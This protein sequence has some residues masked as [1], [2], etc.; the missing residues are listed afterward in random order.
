MFKHIGTAVRQPLDDTYLKKSFENICAKIS[1]WKNF[2]TPG[3]EFSTFSITKILI[4]NKKCDMLTIMTD[5]FIN[6]HYVPM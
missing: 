3:T 5:V 6:C 4:R 2:P 1:N